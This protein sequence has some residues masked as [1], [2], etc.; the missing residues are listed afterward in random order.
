MGL[1]SA[2]FTATGIVVWGVPTSVALYTGAAVSRA[3]H[4]LRTRRVY[5]GRYGVWWYDDQAETPE[6]AGFRVLHYRS[7]TG[8][9]RFTMRRKKD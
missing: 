5:H 9:V 8:N 6:D 1:A 2:F 7:T 4:A 3:V